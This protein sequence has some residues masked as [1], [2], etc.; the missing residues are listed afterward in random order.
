M[1]YL[2]NEDYEIAELNEIPRERAY[3]R[4]YH[5]N[6]DKERAI[7][8]LVGLRTGSRG[9]GRVHGKWTSVAQSNGIHR[10]TFYGRIK[11]GMGYKIAATKPPTK[12]KKKQIS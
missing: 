3:H 4:F 12:R 5:L 8:E 2:T 7:T 6:W 10:N 1:E 9:E 11:A